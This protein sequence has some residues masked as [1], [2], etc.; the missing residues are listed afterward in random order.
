MN[1]L[2]ASTGSANALMRSASDGVSTVP[3]A[4]ALQRMP[5]CTKSAATALVRPITAAF[6]RAV[7]EAVG[8]PLDRAAIDAMLMMLDARPPSAR[9]SS[10]IFGS[11]AR[12][13]TY[14]ARTFRLKLKSQSFGVQ[15]RIVPW[16]T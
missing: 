4:I 3:G 5:F 10:S 9:T 11:A 1:I 12:I 16:W 14:I 15:S 8:Q 13:A 6:D 7:D 2:R